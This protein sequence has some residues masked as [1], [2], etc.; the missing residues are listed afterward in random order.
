MAMTQCPECGKELS[1]K[2]YA[3]PHCGYPM[4]EMPRPQEKRYVLRKGTKVASS[5]FASWLKVLGGIVLIGGLIIAITSSQTV[6]S[7]DRYGRTETEISYASFLTIMASYAVYAIMLFGM[8]GVVENVDSILS[9]VSGTELKS[10]DIKQ[11]KPD[12]ESACCQTAITEQTS[13]DAYESAESDDSVTDRVTQFVEEIQDETSMVSIDK[14]WKKYHLNE[15][16]EEV[17]KYIVQ[18]AIMES[19]RGKLPDISEHKDTIIN[20]LKMGQEA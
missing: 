12:Q 14:I 10:E 16:Y 19:L 17:G 5:S 7:I 11:N 2:A 20:M 9:I 1:D 18:Y 3:C 8:A 13:S 15:S 6:T 4:R